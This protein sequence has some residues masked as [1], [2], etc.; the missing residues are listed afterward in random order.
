MPGQKAFFPEA[1]SKKTTVN[2]TIVIARPKDDPSI[3]IKSDYK[4]APKVEVISKGEDKSVG[5]K[6][7]PVQTAP[8]PTIL[9]KKNIF[10]NI[11]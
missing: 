6:S 1:P 9:S 3:T 8:Q 4:P 11:Y 10:F 2:E 7:I 5:I